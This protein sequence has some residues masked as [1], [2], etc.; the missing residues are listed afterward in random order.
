MGQI[1]IYN[2]TFDNAPSGQVNVS[3][4]YRKEGILSYRY[5]GIF[6]AN[7]DGR[8]VT[9]VVI[10]TE[11]D[12]WYWVKAEVD[13]LPCS[14]E[15]KMY[16]SAAG[17][18]A[19]C[20]AV[21][22]IKVSKQGA[23][24]TEISWIGIDPVCIKSNNYNTG[25]KRYLNRKRVI[26]GVEDGYVEP[27]LQDSDF[28]P[29]EQD[30]VLCPLP[31]ITWT[32]L[33]PVCLKDSGNHNVGIKHY[34]KR[35]RLVSG[36]PDG[37]QE[38]NLPGVNYVPDEQD[39]IMCPVPVVTWKGENPYCIRDA[40]LN[41]TGFVA[42]QTRARMIDGVPDGFIETNSPG[43]NYVPPIYN[44]SLCPLPIAGWVGKAPVCT[45]D[46]S[47]FN[48][49]MVHYTIRARTTNGVEDGYTE[50]N[51]PGTNYVPDYLDLTMCPKPVITWQGTNPVCLTNA[52]GINTGY[53]AYQYRIRIVNGNPDGHVEVNT[54]DINYIP[55][56][57]NTVQ[58]PLPLPPTT[59]IPPTTVPPTT[60]PPTTTIPPTTIPGETTTVP[61]PTTLPPTTTIPP[62]ITWRGASP[63]C[64][65]APGCAAGWVLSPDGTMCAFDETQ[66]PT[67]TSLGYCLVASPS[68][69]YNRYFSRIYNP[70]FNPASLGL[71]S[72]PPADVFAEMTANPQWFNPG[73]VVDGPANR[74]GVW[75]DS[76]CD[77]TKDALANGVQV[78]L[79]W[80]FNNTGSLRTVYVGVFGDNRF[81]LKVNENTI[82]TTGT[83]GDFQ[84]RIFHIFPVTL[85]PGMN[86]F[87]VIGIGDGSV[88]DS[89]GMIVYD[90]TKE[91]IRDAVSDATLH[92]L[93]HSDALIGSAPIAIAT[94]PTGW[95]LDNTN[96]AAPICRRT[97][98]EPSVLKNNGIKQYAIRERLVDGV[99]DGY[100]EAN[101]SGANYVPG[102]A[103]GTMCPP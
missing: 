34:S 21:E 79:S 31:V 89:V 80:A 19:P 64:E 88:N 92:I 53:M 11:D 37:Y 83:T 54:N 14:A 38:D 56:V 8:F 39:L 90:D 18:P 6:I 87:N 32:G 100:T 9:P 73:T 40:A 98:R 75:I 84:F 62:V 102:E 63:Y 47:N 28:V 78:T 13:C 35:A 44:P 76:N 57:Y 41:N 61:P 12:I 65:Q 103:D 33:H 55:P 36:V 101:V 96:P 58:C 27:N 45:K 24:T 23:S 95:I 70:G 74:C 1:V 52:S 22:I 17:Q 48:T 50:P 59:T 51:S 60:L 86:Y 66:A 67:I 4:F 46:A 72:A 7:P 99:A 29:D 20:C 49:G 85:Q 16:S 15:K 71:Y 97:T 77:G 3:I 81:S 82:A 43:T 68:S 25:T 26:N 94:C 5:F 93:F 30:Y 91:A 69:A 2:V 42:Y 10:P